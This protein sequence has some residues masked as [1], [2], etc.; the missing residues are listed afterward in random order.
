MENERWIG[1]IFKLNLYVIIVFAGLYFII[2]FWRTS[3]LLSA[4]LFSLYILGS[5]VNHRPVHHLFYI[6]GGIL[7]TF[8]E[9]VSVNSGVW[10]YKEQ[11]FLG[12]PLWLPFAWGLVPAMQIKFAELFL[13]IKRKLK[14]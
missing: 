2:T 6:S 4:L 14:E 3:L 8:I 1:L 13:R 7:G 10:T 12:V 5:R 9:V 11:F